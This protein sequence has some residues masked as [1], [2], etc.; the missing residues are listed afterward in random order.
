MREV[1]FRNEAGETKLTEHITF[2]EPT[3][4]IVRDFKERDWT[5]TYRPLIQFYAAEQEIYINNLISFDKEN[6]LQLTY[7]FAGGIPGDAEP[8]PNVSLEEM[9]QKAGLAVEKSIGK[10]REL[11]KEGLI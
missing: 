7:S 8:G 11:V 6:N 1:V 3:S 10:I 2:K 5:L 9:S 4:V